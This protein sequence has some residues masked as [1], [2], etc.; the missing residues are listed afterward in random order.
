MSYDEYENPGPY[1]LSAVN[2][3]GESESIDTVERGLECNCTCPECEGKLIARHGEIVAWHFAH[4]H[5]VGCNWR[6]HS[7]QSRKVDPKTV[8]PRTVRPLTEEEKRVAHLP[9]TLRYVA[10]YGW[11][12]D[13]P[14]SELYILTRETY[15]NGYNDSEVL[16]GLWQV[17]QIQELALEK[18]QR[19]AVWAWSWLWSI[20]LKMREVAPVIPTESTQ[21]EPG[22]MVGAARCHQDLVV[23]VDIKNG[24]LRSQRIQEIK[25]EYRNLGINARAIDEELKLMLRKREESASFL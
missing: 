5:D 9:C 19:D 21:G 8:Q 18:C 17:P 6:S 16:N 20:C 15:K 7:R 1:L 24:L 23:A 2:R 22:P 11:T 14:Y 3:S 13:N 10:Q 25:N 12:Q 4:V